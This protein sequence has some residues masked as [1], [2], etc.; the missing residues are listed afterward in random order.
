MIQSTKKEKEAAQILHC[1]RMVMVSVCV[2]A[3]IRRRKIPKLIKYQKLSMILQDTISKNGTSVAKQERLIYILVHSEC[4]S[5]D[6]EVTKVRTLQ[7][8]TERRNTGTKKIK[9]TYCELTHTLYRD[10]LTLSNSFC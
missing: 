3:V 8:M 6:Q 7:A 5:L 9:C 1:D 2:R 4:V 10:K